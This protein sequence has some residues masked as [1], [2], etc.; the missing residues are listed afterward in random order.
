VLGLQKL[1]HFPRI[2]IIHASIL[3]DARPIVTTVLINGKPLVALAEPFAFL[4]TNAPNRDLFTDLSRV[5][6]RKE[7][8]RWT[9]LMPRLLHL[10]M[11]LFTQ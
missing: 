11:P 2:V 10:N 8:D 9:R 1:Q 7:I 4:A 3:Q 5:S 6:Q